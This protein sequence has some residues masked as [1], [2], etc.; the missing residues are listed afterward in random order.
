MAQPDL[1]QKADFSVLQQQ[2]SD[3]RFHTLN[4]DSADGRR[5][6]RVFVGVPQQPPPKDG[7]PVFYALDGNAMLAELTA[8]RLRTLAASG[9]APVVVM[10]GYATDLRLDV[11][12]RAYDYTLA[13][14]ARDT[15]DALHPQRRNGG[16]DAFLD[17]LAQHIMPAIHRMAKVNNTQQTLW[18]H[19]YGGL[20][21]LHTLFTRPQL[22]SRYIAA[23]P[24]IW[25]H[26]GAIVSESQQFVQRYTAL[27][28][29]Q[30]WL[31]KSGMA[32][33]QHA[34]TAVPDNTER[35]RIQAARQQPRNAL[36]ELVQ[37]L[38]SAYPTMSVRY[39]AYPQDT[40]GSLFA[41]SFQAAL[42]G[43]ASPVPNLPKAFAP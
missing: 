15:A 6:Y 33:A 14:D 32:A 39:D 22:F 17:L 42:F 36:P 27:P 4:F 2:H 12:A 26:D 20:L 25:V 5:H 11:V 23:D 29:T 28:P 35:A 1:T 8:P 24:A 3:Y 40:H 19:S 16:A 31:M 30:L 41:K 7:F 38:L 13:V 9:Q 10:L 21:V 43:S 18:G 34:D 37:Q